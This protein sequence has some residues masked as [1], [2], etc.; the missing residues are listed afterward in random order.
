MLKF[1]NLLIALALGLALMPAWASPSIK[2]KILDQDRCLELHRPQSKESASFCYWKKGTG[3]QKQGYL[4]A[5]HILRDVEYKTQHYIDPNLL[6][7]LFLI[8]TWLKQEG[9][10]SQI[11][12][13]SGYRTPTHNFRLE[14]AAKQSLHMKGMAADIYIPGLS[15]KI[16]A[17]MSR[18]V[19]AG[20]VGIYLDKNF[21][22]IDT[23]SIRQWRG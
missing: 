17:L 10:Y 15:T 7:V 20:G 1:H 21:I 18:Y 14:G 5:V 6:D 22:H 2:S 9:R 23:G 16:L 4:Q 13:L 11:H 8:Q 3:F 19:G 12:I